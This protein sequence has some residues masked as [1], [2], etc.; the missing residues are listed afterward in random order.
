MET[1]AQ[2]K[3]FPSEEKFGIVAQMRRCAVSVPSNIAEG[4]GRKSDKEFAQFL[5]ISYGSLC[6]L[7]TQFIICTQLGYIEDSVSTRISNRIT[8]LQKM[9][10]TLAKTEI[11]QDYPDIE[12]ED[13]GGP[14]ISIS[15]THL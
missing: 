5:S 15:N 3:N 13:P 6:E 14:Q 12:S 7:D 4:A 9:I 10:Y 2:T 1:Y 11:K 8:E